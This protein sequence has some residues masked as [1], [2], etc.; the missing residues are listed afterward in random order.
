MSQADELL[1][2]I[3]SMANDADGLADGHIIIGVDR[4]ITVPSDLQRLGVQY[5]HN[6]ETV[7]FDCPR[8]WDGRDLFG[9][10]IYINYMR[11]DETLGTVLCENAYIDTDDDATIHFEWTISGHVTEYAGQ[12][13]MLVCARSVDANGD[14]VTHWNSEL[15]TDMYISVGMKCRDTIVK[16]H[17]DIIT[18]LLTRMDVVED[19][20]SGVAANASA[21]KSNAD[22]AAAS[23]KAAKTSETNAK[24][25]E[26]N[27]ANSAIQAK[28]SVN[29]AA[30]SATA[31]ANSANAAQTSATAAQ[32]SAA[33]AQ[34]SK[35]NADSSAT[36]SR[37]WAVGG[38]NTRSGEDTNNARY[39]SD[40]AQSIA[41]GNFASPEE[42][43]GYAA[44]AKNEAIDYMNSADI[45]CGTW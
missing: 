4:F 23:A 1:E 17:P 5:D 33:A 35:S 26:T 8:Y 38:T 20:A 16:H 43:Q 19:S 22:A 9:M 3:T 42:A 37:S 30:A 39:W 7:T 11:P 13:S 2:S 27:A 25:S 45:D 34:T 24:T 32:T 15:N 12:L 29:G 28:N 14:F 18:Q 41:G 36:L 10:K 21:A 6:V 31:A 44:N 40:R